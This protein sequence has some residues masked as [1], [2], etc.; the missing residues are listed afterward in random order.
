MSHP[1]PAKFPRISLL[2][3]IFL[4][5]TA[6]CVMTETGQWGVRT[7]ETVGTH[8]EGMLLADGRR[9]G[10]GTYTWPDGA[11][12]TGDFLYDA[13]TG[14][15]TFTWPNGATYQGEFKEGKRHGEGTF[16]W[17]DGSSFTG[18]FVEGKKEGIGLF[19]SSA[20]E[21]GKL[22][23]K[24]EET[25]K[26]GELVS[27][28]VLPEDPFGE[29]FPGLETPPELSEEEL[30]PSETSPPEETLQ[31]GNLQEE[32]QEELD[33]R[34]APLDS[35]SPWTTANNT[36]P[37]PPLNGWVAPDNGTN[38]TLSQASDTKISPEME[39]G[40][41]DPD[42]EAE[43]DQGESTIEIP[44]INPDTQTVWKDPDAEGAGME[45]GGIEGEE[46]PP[47]ADGDEM[48]RVADI[49]EA[50]PAVSPLARINSLY[51]PPKKRQETPQT[52]D[53]GDDQSLAQAQSGSVWIDPDTQTPWQQPDP[54]VGNE[55]TDSQTSLQA[56]P[57]ITKKPVDSH[58]PELSRI[59][60]PLKKRA[61]GKVDEVPSTS[62][63]ISDPGEALTDIG[64]TLTDAQETLPEEGWSATPRTD[65]LPESDVTMDSEDNAP[66]MGQ[67]LA[68]MNGMDQ[69]SGSVFDPQPTLENTDSAPPSRVSIR[70]AGRLLADARIMDPEG[71]LQP[72]TK[73][74]P[75]LD[76]GREEFLNRH[77]KDNDEESFDVEETGQTEETFQAGAIMADTL[78]DDS[79]Q[80]LQM[81]QE[82]WLDDTPDRDVAETASSTE[83]K[84]TPTSAI[85]A[86]KSLTQPP[87]TE[88]IS[89]KALE[90]E[91]PAQPSAHAQKATPA[92]WQEPHTGM[93]FISISG[94]C[95]V[96]GSDFAKPNA[97]P[98]H[99]VCLKDFWISKQ[100]TT[101]AQW[102][103]IM[104]ENKPL[105]RGTGHLPQG[106][107][108]WNQVQK[109]IQALNKKGRKKFQ[110]P[111]EAQWEYGCRSGGKGERFCGGENPDT[112]AWHKGNSGE[113]THPVGGK[114]PNGVGLF[115][116]SGNL[117]EWVA[118]RYQAD[119]Y[120]KAPRHDPQ[121]PDR[122][123]TRVYRG[124]AWQSDLEQLQATTRQH[125]SPSRRYPLLGFRL[126]MLESR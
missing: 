68:M 88:I 73:E 34:A 101:Q 91:P 99:E 106:N 25:W 3:A 29:T 105:T 36:P 92:T 100:E 122:G 54:V 72:Y 83:I 41:D 109:F 18:H 13:R 35:E 76:D 11:T 125:L 113:R 6:G 77:K 70:T 78:A 56:T 7:W 53:S 19:V 90:N 1:E 26:N 58:F 42:T 81:A 31:M 12:Y 5:L 50:Q 86:P 119:Y 51:A 45:D 61:A 69:T 108:S 52:G 114:N 89:P 33:A 115:D 38:L 110:L 37:S 4:P 82:P 84:T 121:G 123:R 93:E 20:G 30:T 74:S 64:E 28:R 104:M 102:Q 103:R 66:P 16:T 10:E 9:H 60:D 14:K 39:A 94:G 85:K 27:S 79:E 32:F 116:M 71:E 62:E 24:K 22:P 120:R 111:T 126:I 48:A 65:P 67:M 118:D 40:Q 2:L 75:L 43:T 98:A 8:Y 55:T 117:W 107:V 87:V 95:F 49:D 44:W 21:D 97:T 15:G 47:L 96:M 124:G 17:P 59:L 80:L 63:N 46:P 57:R 23:E 112:L